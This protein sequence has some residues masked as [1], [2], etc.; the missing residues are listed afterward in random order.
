[1]KTIIAILVSLLMLISSSYAFD[2]LD[3]N[4]E[5]KSYFS[6]NSADVQVVS[7]IDVESYT[8]FYDILNDSESDTFNFSNCGSKKCGNFSLLSL[9]DSLND[10]FVGSTIFTINVASE[11]RT[12]FFDFEPPTFSL[13][14]SEVLEDEKLLNL[15]FNYNDNSGFFDDIEL[16]EKVN[17]NL[18]LIKNFTNEKAYNLSLDES[19]NITLVFRVEDLAGNLKEKTLSFL[20]EDIFEP[21]IKNTFLIV[22]EESFNL[23]FEVQDDVELGEYQITQ[24]DLTLSQSLSGKSIV[25]TVDLPFTSGSVNLV[26]S[27]SNGNNV[28]S[29]IKLS[30]STSISMDYLS[31]YSSSKTVKFESNANTCVLTK[32][33]SD[34]KSNK[35][36]KSNNVF[37]L[38]IDIDDPKEY[39]LEYYCENTNHRQYFKQDFNYDT[40]DPSLPE[41]SLRK[42]NDGR[43]EAEWTDSEDNTDSDV[44]YTLYRDGDDIYSGTKTSFKDKKVE[45]P[46]T[47]EYYLEASDFAGNKISTKK[48]SIQPNKVELS[49]TTNVD[50]SISI[51]SDKFTFKVTS[52]IGSTVGVTVKN[53]GE[54]IFS[55]TYIDIEEEKLN[56]DLVLKSGDNEIEVI[57]RDDFDN[58]VEET[59]IV[60][61]TVPSDEV[62]VVEST[63]VDV[64]APPQ[65]VEVSEEP[66]EEKSI[67]WWFWFIVFLLILVLFVW[68]FVL[69]EDTLKE[70][71]STSK[72]S[73]RFN[74]RKDSILG[75]D[76]ER[77]KHK[78]IKRQNERIKELERKKRDEEKQ[79]KLTEIQRQKQ[80]DL[81]KRREISIPFSTRDKSRKRVERIK[82]E[83][84]SQSRFDKEL[85]EKSNKSGFFSKDHKK[86]FDEFS[87]YL[88]NMKSK[89]SF[90]STRDYRYKEKPVEEP[91]KEISKPE[92][93]KQ[94]EEK[95]SNERISNRV[96]PKKEKVDLDGYLG[97]R[98]KKKRWFFVEKEVEKDLEKGRD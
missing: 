36:S 64:I 54:V 89:T 81:A 14:S 18:Q 77:I 3:S 86:K 93:T 56:I 62:P 51:D 34:S 23:T 83:V 26:I 73:E 44:R 90:N 87:N 57:S 94:P 85:K 8:V 11:N 38:N 98:T 52:E 42:T 37:T 45:Y 19:G 13:S 5:E 78:R 75:R 80:K 21:T 15:K 12:I 28:S 39:K 1:M 10:T 88:S 58:I 48:Q 92:P 67:S 46:D 65:E 35:F 49:L 63:K 6:I 68:K 74:G 79:Q 30:S 95:K 27:D 55:Q 9:I 76:L 33:D 71:H 97:K 29:N 16:F 17:G 47:Y 41:L 72:F 31:K 7:S 59:V 4:D 61:Y 69:G 50:D 66:I 53:G 32:I 70:R 84:G 2:I 24:G 20:I 40:K 91:A 82:H 22:R 25:K 43:I 96:G 60:T